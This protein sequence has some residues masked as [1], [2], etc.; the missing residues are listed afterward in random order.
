MQNLV[1]QSKKTG[2]GTDAMRRENLFISKVL[3][4]SVYATGMCKRR[5]NTGLQLSPFLLYYLFTLVSMCQQR[6]KHK[7]YRCLHNLSIMYRVRHEMVPEPSAVCNLNH[8]LSHWLSCNA[9][10]LAFGQA[11]GSNLTA[12]RL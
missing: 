1:T 6:V 4:Y 10:G 2:K 5:S 3:Y 8:K 12:Q 11:L 9:L 7:Q